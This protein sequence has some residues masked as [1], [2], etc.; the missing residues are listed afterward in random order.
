[1]KHFLLLLILCGPL[2]T[3][4]ATKTK[5]LAY[6]EAKVEQVDTPSGPRVILHTNVGDIVLG[7]YPQVAP[8]HVAQILQM[9]KSG[10]YDGARVFRVEPGFVA[11]VANFDSRDV[12]LSP[13]QLATV[14]K[15]PAEF[16]Q[17]KHRRGTLS[18]ARFDNDVNS[19][20]ASFSI[21][22]GEAPHLDGS[23]SVFGEVVQGL[24]VVTAI[25]GTPTDKDSTPLADIKIVSSEIV[26]SEDLSKIKL[27]GVQELTLPNE[28][29]RT[30]FL[31]LAGLMFF[32]TIATPIYKTIRS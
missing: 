23:Y 21:L 20:E 6:G 17:V 24:D 19:A 18:M 9:V 29:G 4:A 8:K 26:E 31:S 30:L 13:E 11:Q 15:I 22:L 16:S 32:F 14:S 12:P 7:F 2:S 28:M 27:N 3:A 10:V 25:E 1:M 5:S